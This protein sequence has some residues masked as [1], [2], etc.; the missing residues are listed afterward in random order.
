MIK[1]NKQEDVKPIQMSNREYPDQATE[2]N[3]RTLR[4]LANDYVLDGEILYKRREDQV[5]LRCVDIV[6][7]KK[8]LEEFYESICETHANRFTM[9]R[10]IMRFGYYWSTMEGDCIN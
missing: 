8:N 4:R 2:N 9:A 10:Q 5:L 7:A 6:E 3:K 1:V